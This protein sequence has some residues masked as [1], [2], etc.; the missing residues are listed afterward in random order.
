MATVTTPRQSPQVPTPPQGRSPV[1]W[2]V[3]A[4]LGVVLLIGG[5]LWLT[6]GG[7]G[8]SI[9]DETAA[10]EQLL[11]DQEQAQNAKDAD[12]MVAMLAEDVVV[13]MNDLPAVVGKDA[14]LQAYAQFWPVMVSADL[15]LTETVVAE[16]G[17]MAW[18]H[19]T[20]V[21]ELDV[22]EAGRVSV[23]GRWMTVMEKIDGEWLVVA[24]STGDI[25][26]PAG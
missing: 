5:V 22:P 11:A 20:Q 14:M 7:S 26:A 21:I 8:V 12:A 1:L 24:L 16:S 13:H 10:L 23:P 17:D 19:G 4:T 25:A 2:A 3:L 6:L 15:N 9:E 18:M